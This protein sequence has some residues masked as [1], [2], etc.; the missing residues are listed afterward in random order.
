[1]DNVSYRNS[2]QPQRSEATPAAAPQPVAAT[3][4]PAP[5]AHHGRTKHS[6][7]GRSP[8]RKFAAL[9]V[10]LAIIVLLVLGWFMMSKTSTASVIDNGKYQAVFFTNGQVYFGKLSTVNGDYMRLKG[11]YYLQNKTDKN[12]EASPQSA[13][14]QDASNVEL[15]KLGNEIH[16]PEDEMLIAKDQVLF[17]E[18]LKPAGTVSQTITNFQKDK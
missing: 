8:K 1:M 3:S 11:V 14:S 17:F 9:I 15:I 18:N 5:T 2:R 7:T 16:G 13:S 10:L 6:Q 12:E 4:S